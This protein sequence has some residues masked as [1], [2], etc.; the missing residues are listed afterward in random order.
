MIKISSGYKP[1]II[2]K[3]ED[4]TTDVPTETI[5]NKKFNQHIV[6]AKT[7]QWT[8]QGRIL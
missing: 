3:G 6:K 8:V 7:K 4:S 5:E 1:G 2:Y